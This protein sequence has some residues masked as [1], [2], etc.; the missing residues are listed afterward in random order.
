MMTDPAMLHGILDKMATAL[1]AYVK[2]QIRSGAQVV[3]IFDSWAHHLSPAQ[4]AEF[5]M[6]YAQ[7]VIDEVRL[8]YA[9]VPLIFHANGG[10][11]KLAQMESCTAD[12]LGLDW[13]TDMAEARSMFPSRV[14]QGNVDPM[15]LFGSE[16]TIRAA[17]REC[18]EAAGP[19]HHILNVG[20]GVVQQTPEE[21]VKLFVQLAHESPVAVA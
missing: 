15:V 4:F 1:V 2:Y 21:N 14:L 10:V 8:D 19:G 11:G 18:C 17:V 9:D 20:H 7:R 3:Q 6:P 12:V 5:S 13:S 16:E